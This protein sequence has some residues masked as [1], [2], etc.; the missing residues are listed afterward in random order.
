DHVAHRHQPDLSPVAQ[1]RFGRGKNL[2]EV[3][4]RRGEPAGFPMT[5]AM[6]A[7]HRMALAGTVPTQVGRQCRTHR[8][9]SS[10]ENPVSFRL[11][12]ECG[13]YIDHIQPH[14][15]TNT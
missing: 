2:A 12:K 7:L 3:R 8:R 9:G 10:L 11:K 4:G 5:K 14:T 6:R 15:T 13:P 1:E